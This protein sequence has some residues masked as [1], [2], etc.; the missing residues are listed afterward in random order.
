[1]AQ[2]KTST[3]V[4]SQKKAMDLYLAAKAIEAAERDFGK[5]Y[6][7]PLG[8]GEEITRPD[9]FLYETLSNPRLN[10]GLSNLGN[11]AAEVMLG[12]PSPSA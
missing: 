2:D 6:I 1:M 4:N 12:R 8:P 3:P 7:E 11:A 9:N 5:T 10:R